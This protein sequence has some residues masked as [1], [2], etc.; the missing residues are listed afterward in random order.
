MAEVVA[1]RSG[2]ETAQ[3][4]LW[5]ERAG[6]DGVVRKHGPP[7]RYEWISKNTSRSVEV[8]DEPHLESARQQAED[9][10]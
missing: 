4:R 6:K 3:A 9:E 8:L 1:E 10:G 2:L 7:S 5:L